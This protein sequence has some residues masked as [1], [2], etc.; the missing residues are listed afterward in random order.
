M[1]A[2]CKKCSVNDWNSSHLHEIKLIIG[3]NGTN[4]KTFK[5]VQINRGPFHLIR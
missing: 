4:Y 3:G 1:H 5:T 2:S